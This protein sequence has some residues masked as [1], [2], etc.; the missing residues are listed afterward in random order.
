VIT[1]HVD[2]SRGHAA[3]TSREAHDALAPKKEAIWQQVM[4]VLESRGEMTLS[5]IAA[6]LG[7]PV[8]SVSGRLTEL[9]AQCII[10]RTGE[11]RLNARGNKEAVWRLRESR[12]VEADGQY[13]MFG[14]QH[15]DN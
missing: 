12:F 7:M 6:K 15:A 14:G 2:L 1:P 3:E 5:E 9:A 13:A 8:N 10:E 4:D 11:R